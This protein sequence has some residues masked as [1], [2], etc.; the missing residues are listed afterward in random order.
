MLRSLAAASATL[1]DN[2]EFRQLLVDELEAEKKWA[3]AI[4]T[5]QP[6]ANDPHESPRRA[7]AREPQAPI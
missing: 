1:P 3:L 2:S 4:A 7:A 6:I 5:L